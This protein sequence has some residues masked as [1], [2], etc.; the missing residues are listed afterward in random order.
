MGF[1]QLECA[2]EYTYHVHTYSVFPALA[3]TDACT[4]D[5]LIIPLP[6]G[7]MP[8]CNVIP[9]VLHIVLSMPARKYMGTGMAECML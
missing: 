7:K 8:W 4:K 5:S 6:P 9:P 3:A 1:Q 2:P